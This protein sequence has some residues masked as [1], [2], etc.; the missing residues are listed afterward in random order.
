MATLFSFSS[1]SA[2]TARETSDEAQQRFVENLRHQSLCCGDLPYPAVCT[3]R[4]S[5]PDSDTCVAIPSITL[6][7]GCRYAGSHRLLS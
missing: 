3:P 6:D 5:L 4:I 7:L 2:K 1:G